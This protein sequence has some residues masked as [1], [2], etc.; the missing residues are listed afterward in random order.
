M[1]ES[2][3]YSRLQTELALSLAKGSQS[4]TEL[5]TSLAKGSW[6]LGRSEKRWDE[7]RVGQTRLAGS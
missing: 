4:L 7:T 3:E 5:A 6:G 1:Y 2:I